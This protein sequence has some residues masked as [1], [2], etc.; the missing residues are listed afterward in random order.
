MRPVAK[1]RVINQSAINSSNQ[2]RMG[3]ILRAIAY[4]Q[5]RPDECSE[6]L[7]TIRFFR[8]ATVHRCA[9]L[10]ASV[11]PTEA[12]FDCPKHT[13]VG[14]TE[15]SKLVPKLRRTMKPTQFRGFRICGRCVTA[16]RNGRMKSGSKSARLSVA[17]LLRRL[18]RRPAHDFYPSLP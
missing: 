3:Q 13:S 7:T 2:R 14:A 5:D 9:H 10:R 1:T 4:R 18:R 16:A 8:E 6:M 17:S 11:R 15:P 12:G